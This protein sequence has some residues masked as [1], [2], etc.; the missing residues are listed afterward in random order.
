VSFGRSAGNSVVSHTNSVSHLNLP[1]VGGCD[2]TN[3]SPIDR[4][5]YERTIEEQ[6]SS[7]IA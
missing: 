5:A 6:A 7:T 2:P 1:A 3:H 4:V